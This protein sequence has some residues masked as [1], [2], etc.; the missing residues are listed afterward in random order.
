MT[1]GALAFVQFELKTPLDIA[2]SNPSANPSR[3]DSQGTVLATADFTDQGRFSI[4]ISGGGPCGTFLLDEFQVGFVVLA[5][6]ND[7]D[8]IK[9]SFFPYYGST[10]KE[11]Y[12]PEP[13][14]N[15]KTYKDVFIPYTTVAIR[16]AMGPAFLP[17]YPAV[18]DI[19]ETGFK[20]LA[21]MS[22]T[23]SVYY[24]VLSSGDVFDG[25]G[26]QNIILGPED[27]KLGNVPTGIVIPSNGFF[28]HTGTF[29]TDAPTVTSDESK[30][31]QE[32]VGPAAGGNFTIFLVP[33]SS[34]GEL[35]QFVTT[36]VGV[37][38]PDLTPPVFLGASITD[39]STNEQEGTFHLSI[40]VTVDEP[41]T[42][43][44]SVYR[45]HSCISGEVFVNSN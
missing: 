6:N 9:S 17:D 25:S 19:S 44:Y 34:G 40:N 21:H 20:I 8:V 4:S 39:L 12:D 31:W 35:S 22:E 38:M 27:I 5:R 29:P 11:K 37:L 18:I 24:V 13:D 30:L 7:G 1:N 32:V 15:A 41:G 45:N 26:S 14:E 28:E 33:E 10:E 43:F 3:K 23:G 16:D 36:I 2:F 42:L